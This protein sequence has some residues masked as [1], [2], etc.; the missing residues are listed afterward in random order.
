MTPELPP[1]EIH[2]LEEARGRH[3]RDRAWVVAGCLV[4]ALAA[5]AAAVWI[6]GHSG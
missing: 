4:I 5:V 3:A 2:Q 6:G 1:A